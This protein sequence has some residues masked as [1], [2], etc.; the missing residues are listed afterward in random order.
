MSTASR[1]RG[2]A[3]AALAVLIASTVATPTH[4]AAVPY[5]GPRRSAADW[6]GDQLQDK[7]QIS[8][9]AGGTDWGLTV[10]TMFQMASDGTQPIRQARTKL[11]LERNAVARYA[12]SGRATFAGPMSKTLLVSEVMRDNPRSFN[13]VNLRR[14]VLALVGPRSAGFQSGRVQDHAG[15]SDTSNV[16]SQVYAVVGLSRSGGVPQNVVSFL[17]KQQCSDGH[18]RLFETASTTCNQDHSPGDVDATALAI[19][20]INAARG[21]GGA[22]VPRARFDG[23]VAWLM[24]HQ[25][26]DGSFN[27]GVGSAGV[28]SNST[29]LA[30]QAFGSAHRFTS[31]GKAQHW[32]LGLQI[33]RRRAGSGPARN[34]IGAIAYD[35]AALSTALKHGITSLTI[36][37]FRRATPQAAFAFSPIPL[38]KLVLPR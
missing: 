4:A 29:G 7:G 13:G 28:N 1:L 15:G 11:A 10:D 36:G 19:E 23:A 24:A 30:A 27:G 32:M 38:A 8:N 35:K 22:T 14:R 25:R 6:Q 34:Q 31:L 21:I 26:A 33:T 3:A 18:F 9:G 37:Q 12:T 16:F 20:A 5:S 2:V 17:L